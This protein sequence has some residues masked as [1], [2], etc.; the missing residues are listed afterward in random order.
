MLWIPYKRADQPA[1]SIHR[2]QKATNSAPLVMHDT[3]LEDRIRS[4]MRS[5]ILAGPSEN[6]LPDRCEP[7]WVLETPNILSEAR[8]RR[9]AYPTLNGLIRLDKVRLY[10]VNS[11]LCRRWSKASL[12]LLA[13]TLIKAPAARRALRPNAR[14]SQ[15]SCV[16]RS[17]PF[18]PAH[19]APTGRCHI[20][21]GLLFY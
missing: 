18:S 9:S 10:P 19:E 7:P 8:F 14:P 2:Y 6:W 3:D 11:Q 5:P 12:I 1:I 20:F 17:V 21:D 4:W 15:H 16:L 13:E